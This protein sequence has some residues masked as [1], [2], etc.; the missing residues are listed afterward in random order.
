MP[1]PHPARGIAFALIC[2][3]IL[4]TM[5]IISN[6]RPAGFDALAFALCLSLWQTVFALP[7]FLFELAAKHKGV[8]SARLSRRQIVRT[9]AI[10]V[11]TGI[12]F[13]LST[14]LYVLGV[15]KAGA[16]N[17]AIAIQAY[18]VFAIL[19][20]SAFLKRHKTGPELLLTA[21]L[22]A[23]LYYLGTGGTGRIEGVSIWFVVALGVP[24]LWSIAHVIIKEELAQIPITP[25][26]ATFFRVLVSSLFLVALV[27][28][29]KPGTFDA[30]LMRWNY[31]SWAL[32]MG[33]VYYL[34]LVFWFHAVRHIDVSLAS[35][36]T[37]PWPA[38]TM[39]L[40]AAFLMDP[41]HPYQVLAFVFILSAIYGLTL[42]QLR[43]T[44][45]ASG[46]SKVAGTNGQ[47]PN[48]L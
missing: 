25:V 13:G 24:L 4:S 5:P 23:A 36:I 14:Y 38:F 35:S 27:L 16:A 10:A 34:E 29:V 40:A 28:V 2:L 48:N 18:P 11:F 43:K 6:S 47:E 22:V 15:E 33:L 7:M 46:S 44:A 1:T 21:C 20:E 26:Q 45:R 3:C 42:M 32:V 19:I 30:E 9:C 17:A 39:V 8:F 37:T 12:L 31:Q 41:I